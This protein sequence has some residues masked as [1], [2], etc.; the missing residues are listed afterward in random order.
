MPRIK[1]AN[2]YGD[3]APGEEL[4]VDEV[5][6]KALRRD[7]M[8]AEVVDAPAAES[9][10]EAS[11]QAQPENAPVQEAAAQPESGRRKR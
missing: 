9:A 8:V 2:W 3:K 5:Q 10:D 4:D 6:L 7:G 1:L 11:A